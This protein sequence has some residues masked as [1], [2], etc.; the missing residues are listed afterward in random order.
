LLSDGALTKLIEAGPHDNYHVNTMPLD[1]V[2][3]SAS[4]RQ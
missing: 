2:Q 4:R 1:A 3:L